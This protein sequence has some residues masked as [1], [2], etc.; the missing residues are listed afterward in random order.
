M[1]A[2]VVEKLER[3]LERAKVG[4]ITNLAFAAVER[5]GTSSD[6]WSEGNSASTLVGG[7]S[8]LLTRLT[9]SMCERGTPIE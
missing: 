6:G 5:D 2:S 8:I 3:L 9:L 4:E 7:V 1:N